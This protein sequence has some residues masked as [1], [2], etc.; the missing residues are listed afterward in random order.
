VEQGGGADWEE[1]EQT[2]G[3]DGGWEGRNRLYKKEILRYVE[4][5]IYRI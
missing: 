1:A 2:L 3:E 5:L 4:I